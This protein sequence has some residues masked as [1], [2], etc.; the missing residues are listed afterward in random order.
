MLSHVRTALLLLCGLALAACSDPQ[1][2]A[3]PDNS[4]GSGRI[5]T[6]TIGITQYPSTLNPVIGSMVA[7]S[8][9]LGF[10][11]R[12]LVRYN[13]E[14][15]TEC[16]TCETLP[17]IGNGLA[18]LETTVDGKPGMAVTWVLKEGQFWGDGT[19]VTTADYAFAREVGQHPQ[20]GA[21]AMET[22]RTM[23][24]LEIVDD[25]TMVIHTDRRF[26][27][28]NAIFRFSPLPA[29][30]ER[31]IFEDAPAE[32]KNRTLYM[33]E[34]T[35][36]GLYSGPYLITET[37]RGSHITLERNPYW[38]GP[39]T[40]FNS[41]TVRAIERTTTLEANLLSGSIDMVAGDLGM[42]IDQALAFRKRHGDDFQVMFKPGLLYEHI[43]VQLDNPI[44][45]DLRVRKA[46][47]YGMDRELLVERLFDDE[48]PVAH[49][50]IHPLDAV[51]SPDVPQY[52]HD[53]ARAAGLLE[54]AG[55]MPGPDGV[56]R[57]AAGEPLQIEIL[58][59]AGDKTR[60]L[61]E[62]VLQS[63]WREVGIDLR[64]RNEAP[65]IFFGETARK[66][67]FDG[68]AMYAWASW[69]EP[70]PRTLLHSTQIP[71]EENGYSGQNYTGFIDPEVDALIESIESTLD[72]DARLP[73]WARLQRI[74][75]EKLPVLPL[76]F[77]TNVDILP[78]W[79][80]GVRQPGHLM[81]TSQWVEEWSV[82]E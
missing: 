54:A 69:P 35:N 22:W 61:V 31:A 42:S 1:P 44:L 39:V 58:S 12:S 81:S 11:H 27:G 25:R 64:I 55:W 63:Q 78:K 3:T 29:H 26:F 59:T 9:V 73:L 41:I 72:P 8:Y 20:S 19:P 28:Y 71:S 23:I 56:R 5:D 68:L 82:A 57:N 37:S 51:W 70:T 17:T 52:K 32:Y 15:V 77:R 67:K 33:T 50:N 18:K 38:T 62:Q 65:R 40:A 48:L 7:K 66:R 53:P 45:A 36:P 60:E 21:I 13:H 4:T 30:L 79:L 74:Y 14:W 46:L 75:A 6:L 10:S 16:Q 43:D 47:M 34:P 80:Q 24:D 2:T 49:S 76:Y